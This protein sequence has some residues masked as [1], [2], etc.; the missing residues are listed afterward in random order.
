MQEYNWKVNLTKQ[1]EIILSEYENR[2]KLK[3][4]TIDIS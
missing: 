1:E 4:N 2:R 3:E